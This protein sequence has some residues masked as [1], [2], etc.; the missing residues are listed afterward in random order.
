MGGMTDSLPQQVERFFRARAESGDW[1][2]FQLRDGQLE[3]ATAVAAAIETGSSLIVEAGTGTGKTLAYLVPALLSGRKVL[4]ST[5]TKA[6]QDQLIGKDLPRLETLIPGSGRWMPLK[7]RENYVCHQRLAQAETSGLFD[8]EAQ[9]QLAAI[10][11]WLAHGGSGV[12]GECDGVPESARVWQAVC[13]KAEFCQQADCAQEGDCLY[14]VLKAQAQQAQ[15]LVVNHH[16]LASDM[17]LRL[18]GA[19]GILPERDI[20][21]VD[22]A[23]QLAGA[24]QQFLGEQVG[25]AQLEQLLENLM[26]AV[27]ADAPDERTVA[28]RHQQAVRQARDALIQS[29]SPGR[30]P[31]AAVR[32]AMTPF[33]ERLRSVLAG[34]H[35]WSAVMAVRGKALAAVADELQVLLE[36]LDAWWRH[37]GDDQV[38]WCEFGGGWFRLYRTPLRIDGAFSAWMAQQGGSWIFTSATLTDTQGFGFFQ[39]RLGLEEVETL[40]VASPFDYARQGMIYHPGGL[41]MPH[42]PD[43]IRQ[44]LRK[45]WPLLQA[46]EGRALLLFSS[47]RSLYEAREILAAHWQGALLVQG[48][49]SKAR[50]LQRFGR[51][52]HALLLATASFW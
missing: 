24:V 36:G 1:P 50:L 27:E 17:A 33:F 35:E 19:P 39:R 9:H 23:H 31:Q 40:Q 8:M 2:G 7:G 20:Y 4:I 15:L 44:C 52:R 3:M 5:A 51:E 26:Q 32:T 6:L 10:R 11:S 28:A 38:C 14:P 43:Y 34:V 12:R 13:A 42:A 21:I 48:E 47:Y 37:E 41:P 49:A 25:S 29:V 30:Y 45:A 46:A 22:E 16:L 18:Q